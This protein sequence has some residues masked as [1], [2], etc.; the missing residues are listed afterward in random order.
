MHSENG[1]SNTNTKMVVSVI[2]NKKLE[3][4]KSLVLE[5]DKKA[6]ITVSSI[7]EVS[8]RGFTEVRFD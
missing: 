6:F 7:H 3:K 4:L 5:I 2:S 8:G 1:Y